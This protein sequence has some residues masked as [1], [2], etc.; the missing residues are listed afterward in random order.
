MLGLCRIVM[1]IKTLCSRSMPFPGALADLHGGN[2]EAVDIWSASV[3]GC[4]GSRLL[5]GIG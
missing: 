3:G 1:V 4:T 5:Q 2:E